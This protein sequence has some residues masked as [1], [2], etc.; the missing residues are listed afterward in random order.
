VTLPLIVRKSLRQHALS[1]VLTALSIALSAGLW[2][3]VWT[4]KEQSQDTFTSVDA[5]F[6]A[7]LGARGSKLQL[8]LNAIFHLEASPGN[9]PWNDFLD[10]QKH[11]SVELAVPLAVGD[12]YR[13]FRL[14][15]TTLDLFERAEYAEGKRFAVEDGGRLFERGYRE[16]VVGSFTARRLNLKPG[17]KFHPYHGLIF[18]EKE[19]HAETYVVTGVLKPSNTPADRVIW[20]PLEGLQNMTGHNP[21]TAT[22]VSAVLVKLRRPE[23][24]FQLD[25]L[26]NKQG[27]RLT[28]AWPTARIMSELFDKIGWFDRVLALVAGLVAFVAATALLVSLYN[29]MNERRREIAILRALGA[30][31]FTVFG[32][33]VLEATA[34][35]ALGVLVGFAV[36]AAI[37]TTAAGVIRAQ[38]GV[39][40]DP[41]AFSPV[42]LWAPGAMLVLGALAGLAPAVKAYRTPVADHLVPSS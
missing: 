9:L 19:Q 3:S 32:A 35:T 18:D 36:Y 31:R 34:I 8:V 11:P 40:L 39:V 21:G 30:R 16:A 1:T 7:V 33:I 42:M 15:G 41:L 25:I 23:L 5:G 20:I 24:G 13:G 17:D 26:Y 12:N 14:V 2:M 28:F 6:D 29:S 37:V 27:N 38:T 4:I 10:I 22:D